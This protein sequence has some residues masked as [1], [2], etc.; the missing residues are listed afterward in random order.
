V[1]LLSCTRESQLD[2]EKCHSEDM[3]RV[4]CQTRGLSAVIC[5]IIVS[6]CGGNYEGEDLS[7]ASDSALPNVKGATEFRRGEQRTARE[8]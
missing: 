7:N 6:S 4:L 3:M 8:A 5:C 1:R 2:R